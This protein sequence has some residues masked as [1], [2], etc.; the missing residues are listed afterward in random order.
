[1]TSTESVPLQKVQRLLSGLMVLPDDEQLLAWRGIKSP[2][3]VR[4]PAIPMSRPSTMARLRGPEAWITRPH[5]STFH[6][7][8]SMPAA[9]A[10]S[11]SRI[12]PAS[13]Q[14]VANQNG[15]TASARPA[16]WHCLQFRPIISVWQRS[17]AY[18]PI[19]VRT[20]RLPPKGSRRP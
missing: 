13:P 12:N 9:R 19:H 6:L 2:R 5:I 14:L 7:F 11:P 3:H 15:G 16:P 17:T 8:R 10:G 20:F 1:C 4:E 18:S